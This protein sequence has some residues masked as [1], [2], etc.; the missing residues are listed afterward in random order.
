MQKTYWW[1]IIAFLISGALLVFGWVYD[2][3]LCFSMTSKNC[4]LDQ[5]RL[6]IIEP[7]VISSIAWFTVSIAL[8][9]VFDKV[10]LKWLR[11]AAIWIVLTAILVGLSPVYSGGWINLNPTKES[12]SIVMGLLFVTLSLA[13]I[14]W[15]SKRQVN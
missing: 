11:F 14:I 13:K 12:V 1:R 7:I 10:F 8:F 5:Y 4:F 2:T 6:V 9:F 15:D 3:Y